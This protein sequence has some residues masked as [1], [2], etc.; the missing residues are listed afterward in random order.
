MNKKYTVGEDGN[1]IVVTDKGE[2]IG[3]GIYTKNTDKIL[4][5]EN[6]AESINRKINIFKDRLK[7]HIEN[8]KI[9]K[10]SMVL[11]P[12]ILIL[13]VSFI[14]LISGSLSIAGT[15]GLFCIPA[16]LIAEIRSLI[17]YIKSKKKEQIYNKKIIEE[18]QR[19]NKI[20]KRINAL[21][22]DKT[23]IERNNNVMFTEIKSISD[24]NFDAADYFVEKYQ[25]DKRSK[26]MSKGHKK[27]KKIT[28]PDNS[29]YT[30]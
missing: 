13:F 20:N 1:V 6:A 10:N 19:V 16:G 21:S 25:I 4:S 9:M 11:T 23:Q 8:K 22:Q 18:T 24:F 29:M 15:I 30:M 2:T 26:Q 3:K 14:S 5:L 28:K 12:I 27:V 7:E 17:S